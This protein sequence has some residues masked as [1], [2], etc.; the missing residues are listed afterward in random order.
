MVDLAWGADGLLPVIIQDAGSGEVLTLAYAN[1]EA[2]Q[3]TIASRSTH[4]FSRSRNELWHKGATS[5]NTQSVISVSYDCDADALL[6]RV[7]PSG[8]AC[9]T[10]AAKC[11]HNALLEGQ[12]QRV[13]GGHGAFSQ[14]IAHLQS[15]LEERK[16]Q[17]PD[18][19]YVAKL[20]AG[21][22][23]RIGK[24]IGEEA[25]EVV[26]AAKNADRKELI[27]EAADLFFHVLVLLRHAEI[28]LDEIGTELLGRVR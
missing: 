12:E 21:G 6:Y 11:F 23:D 7:V 2:L 14:A 20:Y 5:G 25:T 18:S 17:S 27:W 24:K 15:V 19:S 8:P 1:A 3:K 13:A 10:G 22:V 28:S 16:N 26:I 4:L 9:H